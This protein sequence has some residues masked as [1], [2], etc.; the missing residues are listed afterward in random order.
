MLKSFEDLEVWRRSHQIVLEI[1]RL[2]NAFPKEERFGITSQLR[3][4]AYS[5]PANIAEGLGRRSTKELIQCLG[6][7]NGSL[8]EVR[9]FVYLSCDLGYLATNELERPDDQLNSVAQMMAA[10]SR[11]LKHKLAVRFGHTRVT[12]HGSRVIH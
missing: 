1:Y 4:A 2:T 11:T 6:I 8:K 7:A 10:L 9:Y 3:R 12:G 5:V